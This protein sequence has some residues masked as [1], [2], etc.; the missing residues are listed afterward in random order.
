MSITITPLTP[1]IGAEISDIDLNEP[2]TAPVIEEIYEALVTHLVV[3]FRKQDLTPSAHVQFSAQFGTLDKPHPI[4]PQVEGFPE[5][6]K[7]ENNKDI[8]PDNNEWHAD[9]TFC[10]NPPF[11]SILHAVNVPAMGG[12]TLWS[13]MHAAYDALPDSIKQQIESLY[14]VHDMGPFRNHA[15]GEQ[16][17]IAELN[18]A[19]AKTGSAVHPMVKRHPKTSRPI[20]YVNQS[21]TRHVVGMTAGENDRLLQYLYQHANRPEFQ[22]RFHW[23]NGDIAMWDN[24]ATHHYANADYYPAQRCMHRVTVVDDQRAPEAKS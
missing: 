17:D 24:R 18:K 5:I 9:L 6:V 13:S 11:A 20:L 7:L 21:F 23:E 4:Y 8:P 14:A 22:V 19:L 1:S 2:L 10:Q 12:D 3:F 16:H 15:L